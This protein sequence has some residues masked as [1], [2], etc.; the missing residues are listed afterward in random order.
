MKKTKSK[1]SFGTNP[2]EEKSS[3]KNA[4]RSDKNRPDNIYAQPNSG[5]T[6]V[7]IEANS[8]M[9]ESYRASYCQESDPSLGART[10]DG[11]DSKD[12]LDSRKN[13]NLQ[14]E[15]VRDAKEDVGA[16]RAAHEAQNGKHLDNAPHAQS[17]CSTDDE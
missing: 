6:G 16:A 8:N 13:P 14:F 11:K 4:G 9:S 2:R 10:P 17:G 1:P 15:K 7:P 3:S 5:K 12:P